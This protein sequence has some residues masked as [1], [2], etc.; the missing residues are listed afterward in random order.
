MW[1]EWWRELGMEGLI[2]DGEIRRGRVKV[3]ME[4]EMD[5]RLLVLRGWVVK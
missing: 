4:M 3:E 2:V 5:S 1:L